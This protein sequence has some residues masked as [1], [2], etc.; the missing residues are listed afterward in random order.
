M[1]SKGKITSWN[2]EKGYG[3]VTPLAGGRQV[4]IHIKA[5]SNRNRRPEVNDIVAFALS[6]DQQG[7]PCAAEATLA[8][9]KV[10]RNAPRKSS[11]AQIVFALLFLATVGMFVII[12]RLPESV[13]IAYAALSLITFT[14]YAYDKSAAH[15]DARRTPEIKL[16]LLGLAGGWPGA[17]VAQQ[18]L[19]HKSRKAPFRRV[20]WATVSINCAAF[21]WLYTDDGRTALQAMLL[22]AT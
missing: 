10:A 6:T 2:D 12:G 1:R 15:K 7:R 9:D 21:L 5:F 16:L 17:L 22:S 4:F 14:A 19:R 18:M 3:F 8:G 11:T 13:G 20:F